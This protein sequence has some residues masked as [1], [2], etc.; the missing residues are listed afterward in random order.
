[1]VAVEEAAAAAAV[2]SSV[3]GAVAVVEGGCGGVGSGLADS[4]GGATW[5]WC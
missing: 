4:A 5:G 3:V 2:F 1:M